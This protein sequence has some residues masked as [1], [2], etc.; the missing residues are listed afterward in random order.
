MDKVKVYNKAGRISLWLW[1]CGIIVL[2]LY[3]LLSKTFFAGEKL[4]FL[5]RVLISLGLGALSNCF[6]NPFL[7][8]AG[9]FF[10]RAAKNKIPPEK[11]G[12]FGFIVTYIIVMSFFIA[13]GVMALVRVEK[14]RKNALQQQQSIMRNTEAP[15]AK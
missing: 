13:M 11:S 9:I 14:A 4:N 12:W 3:L 1:F 5:L 15:K 7:F 6:Y 8:I 2:A 10:W